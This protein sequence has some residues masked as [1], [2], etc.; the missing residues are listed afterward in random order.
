VSGQPGAPGWIYV[1]NTE[2]YPVLVD[3]LASGRNAHA[4]CASIMP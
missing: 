3:M 4:A 1:S 2:N